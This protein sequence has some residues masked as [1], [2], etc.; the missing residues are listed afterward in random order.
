MRHGLIAACILVLAS[1]WF[2][3]SEVDQRARKQAEQLSR[4]ISRMQAEDMIEA[5]LTTHRERE[6]MYFTQR[7]ER[8]VS[9]VIDR[10]IDKWWPRLMALLAALGIGGG[11]YG[12]NALRMAA[13]K[14]RNGKDANPAKH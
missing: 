14:R 7:V 10:K 13:N 11:G 9:D 8:V 12:V 2:G 5:A 3:G 1:G 6:S 4:P